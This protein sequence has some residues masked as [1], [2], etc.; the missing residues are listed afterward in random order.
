MAMRSL[1]AIV[2]MAVGLMIGA[3]SSLAD[4]CTWYWEQDNCLDV[5]CPS[6]CYQ[7]T[8]G[9]WRSNC[10]PGSAADICCNCWF[11]ERICWKISSPSPERCYRS[12]PPA[13]NAYYWL[14]LREEAAGPC[15]QNT[16]YGYVC[17]TATEPY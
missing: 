9:A 8:L 14:S 10:A 2:V 15:L 12:V 5:N 4:W 7:S 3:S 17:L 13:P 11:R 1:K 16:Q 6:G